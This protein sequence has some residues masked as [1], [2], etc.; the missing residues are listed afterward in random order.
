VV[1]GAAD[2]GAI[3]HCVDVL[4]AFVDRRK[5]GETGVR[6]VQS[7]RG[8][9]TWNWVERTAWASNLL[10]AVRKNFDLKLFSKAGGRTSVSW[11]ITMGPMRR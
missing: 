5:G 6:S 8:P 7:I 10:E 2:E 4:Q 3:F 9:E 11:S 1:G